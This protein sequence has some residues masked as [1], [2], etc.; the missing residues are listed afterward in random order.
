MNDVM[1]ATDWAIDSVTGAAVS[2]ESIEA[3]RE[4]PATIVLLASSSATLEA[5]VM[6]ALMLST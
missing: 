5:L 6:R 3:A 1:T 2:A 4:S